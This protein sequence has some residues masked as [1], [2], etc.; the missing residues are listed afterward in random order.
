MNFISTRIITRFSIFLAILITFCVPGGGNVVLA[1]SV[2]ARLSGTVYDSTGAVVSGATVTLHRIETDT[3]R[4][5]NDMFGFNVAQADPAMCQ[6][7]CAVNAQCVA[8]TY[9]KP[10]I[11]GPAPRCYLKGAAPAPA[12]NTCCV[13]GT[14]GS[15]RPP[16]L[17]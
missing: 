17:R 2:L 8:W 16:L 11:Q 13:S 6:T 12:R 9:V 3:D 10:G 7:A 5:G 14:K 15:A 1:Q 4:P